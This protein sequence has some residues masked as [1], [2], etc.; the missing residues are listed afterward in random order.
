M[1]YIIISLCSRPS[2]F[3]AAPN[4]YRDRDEANVTDAMSEIVIRV[5]LVIRFFEMIH[6]KLAES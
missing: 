3:A 1:H 2:N 5:V 4:Y 6:S